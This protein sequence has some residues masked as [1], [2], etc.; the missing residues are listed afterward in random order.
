MPGLWLRHRH[1]E[2]LGAQRREPGL[3]LGVLRVID[4]G[5]LSRKLCLAGRAEGAR[6]SCC[7]RRLRCDRRRPHRAAQLLHLGH[8]QHGQ[9]EADGDAHVLDL[10]PQ[11]G[12]H[13]AQQRTGQGEQ[14]DGTEQE[15]FALGSHE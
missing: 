12:G 14:S 10:Q 7:W 2:G 6:R 5:G 4:P 3:Q 9:E 8:A 13:E 11:A 15:D 1:V